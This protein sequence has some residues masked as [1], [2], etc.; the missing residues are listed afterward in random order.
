MLL[1]F[2]TTLPMIADTLAKSSTAYVVLAEVE[3]ME[4]LGV[5]T[6]AGGGLTNTYYAS[7]ATQVSMSVG[8][9][10]LYRRL[11][12]VRLNSVYLVGRTTTADVDANLGSYFHDTSTARIYVSTT[13]GLHP[14]SYE[15]I[16]AWF[17]TF[18]SSSSVSFDNQPLFSPMITGSLP[19]LD[20]EMPDALFG[21]SVSDTGQL[22]LL[23]GDGLFDS[24][25]NGWVWRNKRVTLR[26]GAQGF[27]YSEFATVVVMRINSMAVTD[28]VATLTL[29]DFGTVLN[30]SVPFRTW[31]DGTF[32]GPVINTSEESALGLHQPVLFGTVQGC[33]LTRSGTVT[34]YTV[35]A[36]TH[37]VGI[38]V[39]S[40]SAV[41]NTT[42]DIIELGPLDY[43]IGSGGF[44]VTII[45]PYSSDDYHFVA[46]LSDTPGGIPDTQTFGGFARAL[47]LRCGEDPLNLD[48]AAFAA[49]SIPSPLVGAFFIDPI[50]AAD[51][52]RTL[53]QSVMGQ[54]YQGPDGRWTCRFLSPDIPSDTV[55]VTS[56]VDSDFVSWEP[57][58]MLSSVLHEV[59]VRHSNKPAYDSWVEVSASDLAVAYANETRDSH[60]IDTY[61]QNDADARS[62]ATRM[63]FLRSRP[64]SR[65]DFEERGLRTFVLSAG[66]IVRV[67]RDRAPSRSG[68][69]DGHLLRVVQVSKNL[70]SDTPIATGV[71]DDMGGQTERVFRLAPA[72]STMTWSTA[73]NEER[74]I[75]GFLSD[76]DRYV[77]A[78]D[79]A[80]RDAKSLY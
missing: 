46:T 40:V 50:Q 76:S 21:S 77:V 48:D 59:R 31:G 61:L 22:Q 9:G 20:A 53:E 39:S 64:A 41:S 37:P 62:L 35:D 79:A 33:P 71:L 10:G 54:V 8:P 73:T 65:I 43:V 18:F 45:G 26:L 12:S 6:S 1:L 13:G 44:T 5:W 30:Q 11:D 63:L 68:R 36:Q 55:A 19:A 7:F 15:L 25:S 56:L 67:T 42:G 74:A 17:T 38:T 24:L 34:Y 58:A 70:G 16:G 80:S 14:D 49:A 27:T 23:N 52:M 60:R 4:P 32:V 51:I 72:G 47:L 75:Y 3:A 28:D 2:T 66:D 57:V 29:E 69:Y 78:G